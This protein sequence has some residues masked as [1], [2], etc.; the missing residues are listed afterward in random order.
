[1]LET[2][3]TAGDITTLVAGF[4]GLKYMLTKLVDLAQENKAANAEIN[5]KLEGIKLDAARRDGDGVAAT[6]ALVKSIDR[7]DDTVRDMAQQNRDAAQASATE[8][9]QIAVALTRLIEG[10]KAHQGGAA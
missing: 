3:I 6:N 9:Q 5:A 2:S 4:A 10:Q 1:M 8:H 7:L